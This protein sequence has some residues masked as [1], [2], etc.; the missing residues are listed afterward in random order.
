MKSPD[1]NRKAITPIM[2]PDITSRNWSLIAT[3]AVI[4]SIENAKSVIDNR[5]I[6]LSIEYSDFL[7]LEISLLLFKALSFIEIK[8]EETSD[9]ETYNEP[10][11]VTNKKIPRNSICPLCNSGKKYKHCCGK[12]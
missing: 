6:T 1:V 2:A 5:S 3:A 11:E 4:L 12:Y 8:Q 9:T 10:Q 7:I